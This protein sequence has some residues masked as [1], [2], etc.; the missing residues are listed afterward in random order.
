VGIIQSV[1]SHNNPVVRF[2]R[3]VPNKKI[4]I[5]QFPENED[6]SE[7]TDE[8]IVKVLPEPSL[9]RR[10]EVVFNIQFTSYNIQ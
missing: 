5:F 6:I 1:N 9:G 8:D 7:V 10:G 4:N 3:K 2:V